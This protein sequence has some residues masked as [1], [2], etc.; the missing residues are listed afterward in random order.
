MEEIE[1]QGISR[2]AFLV[3]GALATGA[4]LGAA[5]VTPWVTGALAQ[6]GGGDVDVLNF[7]LTLEYLEADFYRQAA[8]VGL[9]GQYKSLAKDFGT[10][11]QEH[12]KALTATI[13]QLGGK[14]AAKPT[15]AFGLK[16]QADF[17]K[18]AIT[19]EDT[20]VSA[21]NGAAPMIQSKEVL[22][23]AGGIVQVEA[24][25][26]AA[27]RFLGGMDPTRGAF[28]KTLSKAKVLKA[29]KPLIKA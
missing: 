7:A 20:G 19:L 9:K 6:S 14:P 26:A 29:V 15:F 13:K 18:L 10:Q 5:S 17:E 27:L 3:R 2:G 21:Y 11:E 1:I 24:R 25:H 22:A 23:A 8:K 12:V 4:A 28:D 16:S